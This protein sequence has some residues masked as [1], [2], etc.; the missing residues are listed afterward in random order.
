MSSL[1]RPAAGSDPVAGEFATDHRSPWIPEGRMLSL[2]SFVLLIAWASWWGGLSFYAIAVV[3]IATEQLGSTSQGFITRDVTHW[4]NT[5]FAAFLGLLLA[6]AFR[7]RSA[8][9]WC[10]V[11]M[12]FGICVGLFL[13]H[14]YLSQQM[15]PTQRTVPEGFYGDHAV[16][17]WLT[18]VEWFLGILV[19]V[20]LLPGHAT[21]TTPKSAA[22]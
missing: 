14:A 3:P 8:P 2:W 10:V 5:L 13:D 17:L 22:S 19:L 16:Y 9:L 12:L 7:R 21:L 6:E 11:G 15:D 4:H 18:A 20:W 1:H